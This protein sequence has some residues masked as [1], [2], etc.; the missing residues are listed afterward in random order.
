MQ[1]GAW[2]INRTG[3]RALAFPNNR[4]TK[5]D[6]STVVCLGHDGVCIR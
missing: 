3:A 4:S 2:L 5:S 6:S 1:L